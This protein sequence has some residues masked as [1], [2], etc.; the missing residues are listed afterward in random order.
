[1]YGRKKTGSLWT[2]L[3][4]PVVLPLIWV[5]FGVSD[6]RAL[7][8]FETHVECPSEDVVRLGR[9]KGQLW[10]RGCGMDCTYEADMGLM[11]RIECFD[12]G[13]WEDVCPAHLR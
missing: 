1:M 2:L 13:A 3:V 7:A 8:D 4:L 11:R 12:E 6:D 9:F 5:L 10:I